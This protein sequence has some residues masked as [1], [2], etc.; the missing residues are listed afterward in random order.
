MKKY[1]LFFVLVISITAKGQNE[2][3]FKVEF[4]PN[5]IYKTSMIT[6]NRSEI[7]FLADEETLAEITAS[8][9]TLPM[10]VS[11]ST[12]M[13]TT[14]TTGAATNEN[15]IPVRMVYGE[16]VNKRTMNGEETIQPNPITGLILEGSYQKGVKLKVDTLISETIDNNM[17]SA[18]RS[19]LENVQQQIEFPVD[20]LKVGD[21]FSQELPMEIPIAGIK[22]IKI[23]IGTNYTLISIKN[24]IAFFDIV[25]KV[26]L[27][28]AVEQV[29]ISATGG[30][31][32]VSE[33]DIKNGM[34]SK[35]EVAIDMNMGI[36]MEGITV[37]AKVKTNTK[38]LISVQ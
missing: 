27:N 22:S 3:S 20:P 18:I 21:S 34:I 28:M 26:A 23:V 32:G 36:V 30:G 24:G 29:D 10:I 31:K 6:T 11:G 35:Y 33:F 12:E 9:I 25:Q 1:L 14:T 8:G 16:V 7:N 4:R 2:V 5:K 37:E 19:M 38:Q 17:R 13:E 15:S